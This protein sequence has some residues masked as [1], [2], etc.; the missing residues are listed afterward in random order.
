MLISKTIYHFIVFRVLSSVLF[1]LRRCRGRRVVDEK[2]LQIANLITRREIVVKNCPTSNAT[3]RS[4]HH[5]ACGWWWAVFSASTQNSKPYERLKG[6]TGIEALR[7]YNDV[8]KDEKFINSE[9]IIF[10]CFEK[11]EAATAKTN[12]SQIADDIYKLRFGW[13]CPNESYDCDGCAL[14]CGSGELTVWWN[15]W[16]I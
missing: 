9:F 2:N 10:N 5:I 12:G 8:L 16:N 4:T 15:M 3:F 6:L 7:R 14:I 13:W 11:R 1:T